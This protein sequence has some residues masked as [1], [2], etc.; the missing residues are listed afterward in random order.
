MHSEIQPEEA[1]RSLKTDGPGGRLPAALLAFQ[2]A[3][4]R[5]RRTVRGSCLSLPPWIPAEVSIHPPEFAFG[6]ERRA[7]GPG[8]PTTTAS[9]FVSGPDGPTTTASGFASG[10]GGPMTTAS[11][12]ASGPGGPM[13]TPSGLASDPGGPTM[14]PSGPASVRS[15]SPAL[16]Q[17]QLLILRQKPHRL[18]QP[19]PSRLVL[20][21]ILDPAHIQPAI[22]GSEIR[23]IR[24]RRAVGP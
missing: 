4:G 22:G 5:S 14:T 6:P 17:A 15:R 24:P 21:G 11:G 10:P 16:F 7:S 18:R 23:E 9:G 2:T 13:T 8:G 20:L 1:R 3:H 12:F 19:L